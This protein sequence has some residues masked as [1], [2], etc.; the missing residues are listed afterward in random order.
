MTAAAF[1]WVP[2]PSASARTHVERFMAAHGITAFDELRRR[3][4]AEPEWFWNAVVEFLGIPFGR[5]YT[6]VLDTSKGIEW[7]TWFTGG[8]LNFAVAC[9]DRWVEDDGDREAL[10]W[11]GEDGSVRTWTYQELQSETDRLAF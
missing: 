10:V 1:A 5:P 3:S 6:S 8:T 7:A 9:V 11:E 2:E 4:V